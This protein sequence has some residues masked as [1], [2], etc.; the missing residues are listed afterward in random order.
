MDPDTKR[1]ANQYRACFEA[2]PDFAIDVINA[3]RDGTGG[4]LFDDPTEGNS[5]RYH[6]HTSGETCH[7]TVK[8]ENGVKEPDWTGSPASDVDAWKTPS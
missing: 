6:E 1:D 5:C 8:F 3:V 4:V 7:K 2:S